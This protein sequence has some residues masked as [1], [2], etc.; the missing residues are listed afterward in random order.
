VSE[1]R[2]TGSKVIGSV[3]W[4]TH[5]CQFYKTKQDLLDI[6]VPYFK[7]GLK[8][9]E[10]C[11]WVTAEPLSS[12]EAKRAIAKRMPDFAQYLAKGQIEIMP[13]DK[14]YL[15]RGVFDLQRVLDGWIDKLNQALAKGYS[16]LRLTG[17][18]FWIRRGNWESFKDYEAA[19][20]DVIGQYKMLAL[21]TY[22]L[23]K[24]TAADVLDVVRNHEFALIKQEGKWE[25]LEKSGYSISKIALLESQERFRLASAASRTTVYDIF[26]D[27]GKVVAV[28]GFEELLGYKSD[29]V[30]LTRRWW[31]S[32]MHPDDFAVVRKQLSEIID[33]AQDYRLQYRMRHKKGHYLF[34]EDTAKIVRDDNGRA[35]HIVGAI[36]DITQR[37]L[38]EDALQYQANLLNNV[39]DAVIATDM[40]L[41][42]R[43]WNRAA[44][45]A[46]GW[47][48]EEVIGKPLSAVLKGTF[49][50]SN[51]EQA[52]TEISKKGFWTGEL[53]HRRKDGSAAYMFQSASAFKD[54][55]GNRAGIVMVNHDITQLKQ[56]EKTL[57]ETSDYLNNLLEYANAPIIVWDPS[58]RI[59]RF[60]HAFEGLT[61]QRAYEVV[62][63]KLDI[64]FPE[65]SRR[66]SL[67]KIRRT[68]A[69]E[70]WEAVEIP[71]IGASREVRT[72]LWNSANVYAPDGK[73]IIATIAQGQDITERKQAE[74]ALIGE[75]ET[76]QITIENTNTHLAYLDPQFNFV[77]VNSAYAIGSGYT[78]EELIGKNHFVLFP[79][80]EN[81]AIFERVRDTGKAVEF[82]DKPFVFSDQ[83]ERG[84]T[85]WDWTLTPVKGISGKVEG[86][87]LSL[88]DTTTRKQLDE[89]KDE[90]IGLVSH[91]MRTPLTVII[92]ALHTILTEETRLSVEERSQLLQDAVWEAESLSHLLSNLLE[93]SR[94]QSERLLL[95]RESIN[96]E[97]LVQDVF[98]RMIQQSSSHKFIMDVWS[99]LPKIYAD[100]VRLEHILRNLLENAVKYSP[101]DSQ[102]TVSIKPEKESLVVAVKDQG[103]GIS[104]HDQEKLFK[105]FE[106][107]GFSQDITVKGVGL[108]LLVCKRLVEA[109]GGR[110]WVDSEPGRGA[111]FLFTLP[112]ERYQVKRR[113][114]AVKDQI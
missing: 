8:S 68:V 83:S 62:G 90:F 112:L 7:T 2:E 58:F 108:G 79:D 27:T 64:L 3:P 38:A 86:L 99:R 97:A 37:K 60:N 45:R 111:T 28:S 40:D 70:R 110:V 56:T 107:L 63:K 13:H 89:L 42:I 102:I 46:Y 92:G 61:G 15:E 87:V 41:N 96:I 12:G 82:R 75:K 80:K 6:L 1:L 71:I 29:E 85:Y 47:T 106:R 72:V 32:Q 55:A 17:N 23:D 109:H 49:I 65:E 78:V 14:W 67:Q 26:I 11:M 57:R 94:A 52:L 36:A 77:R 59:T 54:S 10:F 19:V 48:P 113:S 24:C 103:V 53:I 51:R 34:V 114:S 33:T 95:H 43:A 25:L 30:S 84:T 93:L 18:T 74:E 9:N 20:S 22:S 104:L 76:L 5:F 66:S 100:P 50:D 88:I 39:S 101:R 69:G 91:E 16:G 73:T 44:E 98:G 4:G 21:C 35:V 105:P 81:Q 31:Y